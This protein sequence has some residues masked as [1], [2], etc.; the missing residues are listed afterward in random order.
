M[1]QILFSLML[2]LIFSSLALAATQDPACMSKKQ[3][4]S[5]MNE[6]VLKWKAET[7]NQYKNRALVEGAL[8]DL[9]PDKSGHVHISVR[10]G[11]NN[12]DTVEL[13]YNEKFGKL[14]DLQVGSTVKACGGYITSNAR[15]K[16]YPPSPD[17][18]IIHWVHRSTNDRHDHG[19]MI[20][21]NVVYGL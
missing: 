17:G 15:T 8:V 21:D 18:A 5:V 1:K 19:F 7:R 20:I 12:K 4:L 3:E 6:T 13:V 2:P 10:I 16:R 11:A 14:P 9:Y